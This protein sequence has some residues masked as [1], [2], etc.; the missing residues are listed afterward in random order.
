[1]WN[2][3]DC[4]GIPN[5]EGSWL[6][7]IFSTIVVDHVEEEEFQMWVGFELAYHPQAYMK[8]DSKLEPWLD[9]CGRMDHREVKGEHI[10]TES[11]S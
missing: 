1:M 11:Y 7:K 5:G 9:G 6:V 2:L 3:G 8:T 4:N 10:G